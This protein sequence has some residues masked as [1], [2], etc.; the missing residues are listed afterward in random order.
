MLPVLRAALNFQ[1]R[2]W[3]HRCPACRRR[4]SRLRLCHVQRQGL[5]GHC[6]ATDVVC[7]PRR[8]STPMRLLYQVRGSRRVVRAVWLSLTVARRCAGLAVCGARGRTSCRG[9]GSR[10]IRGSFCEAC[11]R[12]MMSY[13]PPAAAGWSPPGSRG[14][15]C[16]SERACEKA[17]RTCQ[18]SCA[19]AAS[20]PPAGSRT[21][22]SVS[23]SRA[24]P[25]D[26][27][28]LAAP[29][30]PCLHLEGRAWNWMH[31]CIAGTRLV[32]WACM[33]HASVW[34]HQE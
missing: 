33:L 16:C 3:L 34:K 31:S 9:S 21:T 10:C 5:R 11:T 22:S 29:P 8:C 7:F 19:K 13:S 24:V 20:T 17:L 12:H 1:L 27:A 14:S 30:P 4:R 15:F 23:S 32:R 2:C 18:W 26:A 6:T 28:C 25:T